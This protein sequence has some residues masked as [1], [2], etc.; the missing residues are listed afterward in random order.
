MRHLIEPVD[1][2]IT[3]EL[4]SPSNLIDMVLT[5]E[6]KV[7]HDFEILLHAV[8]RKLYAMILGM[9]LMTDY[10]DVGKKCEKKKKY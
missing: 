4:R 7:R 3:V 2:H 8:R 9:D 6:I 5:C 1:R 10:L